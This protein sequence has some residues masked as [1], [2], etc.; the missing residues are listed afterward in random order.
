M[1]SGDGD[2]A[3]QNMPRCAA[4][5]NPKKLRCKKSFL[6]HFGHISAY[7]GGYLCIAQGDPQES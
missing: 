7:R 3:P 2:A 6:R 5:I 4:Q 1:S